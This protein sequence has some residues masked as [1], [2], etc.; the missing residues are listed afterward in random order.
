MSVRSRATIRV[1]PFR[2]LITLLIT[3]LLIPLGL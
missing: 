1:S 2:V 3:Y